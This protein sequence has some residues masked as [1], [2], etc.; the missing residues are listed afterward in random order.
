ML[1]IREPAF[2]GNMAFSPLESA[3]KA[4][5]CP[6]VFEP[7]SWSALREHF[8]LDALLEV[9][10]EELRSYATNGLVLGREVLAPHVTPPRV[11]SLL[12]EVGM[13]YVELPMQELC[14]RAGGASRCLVSEAVVL[15]SFKVPRHLTLRSCREAMGA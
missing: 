1:R 2:H 7:E 13:S 14:E 11:R 10:E 6:T 4:L 8:G 15:K 12:A 3:G 5:V 9:S